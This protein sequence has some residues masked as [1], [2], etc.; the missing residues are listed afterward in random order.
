MSKTATPSKTS[1]PDTAAASKRCVAC[2]GE[3]SAKIVR[4]ANFEKVMRFYWDGLSVDVKPND[5]KTQ[6]LCG[7]CWDG[8]VEF[9]D[10]NDVLVLM[11]SH[12]R[13]LQKSLITQAVK[14]IET[15][16]KDGQ[17]LLN[18]HKLVTES[19]NALDFLLSAS[20]SLITYQSRLLKLHEL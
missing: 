17:P 8:L 15:L 5:M 18:V 13:K 3:A 11:E 7:T 19:K 10:T 12:L 14:G 20:C 16:K 6:E 1:E 4:D 9:Y 2:A